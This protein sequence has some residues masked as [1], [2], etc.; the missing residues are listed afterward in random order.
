MSL[1]DCLRC[2]FVVV[3]EM[4]DLI[5]KSKRGNERMSYLNPLWTETT[6]KIKCVH[7][8]EKFAVCW[9]FSGMQGICF[10]GIDPHVQCL[11]HCIDLYYIK[12][13]VRCQD[14]HKNKALLISYDTFNDVMYFA[15][16]S[17]GSQSAGIYGIPTWFRSRSSVYGCT[18][19]GDK[20][21][22]WFTISLKS[23]QNA[24]KRGRREAAQRHM[25]ACS[26]WGSLWNINSTL[27]QRDRSEAAYFTN[28]EFS[29][30][31]NNSS[32]NV[33]FFGFVCFALSTYLRLL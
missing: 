23:V 32:T 6:W 1:C 31:V 5:L 26:P 13:A 30:L 28:K 22:I 4:I 19:Q 15:I 24:F 2:L 7:L 3:S 27:P 20:F 25:W 16:A 17:G 9:G 12:Q 10:Q 21:I 33:R 11:S 18:W 8:S 29:S 14:N